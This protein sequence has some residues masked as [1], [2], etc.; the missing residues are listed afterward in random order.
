MSEN[1]KFCGIFMPS[2]KDKILK[3]S[4]CMKSDKMPYIIYAGLESLIKEIGGSANIPEKSSSTKIGQHI[5]CGYSMSTI[6]AF[7]I[8]ENEHNLYRREK[9]MKIFCNSKETCNNIIEFET[10]KISSLTKK[11][12]KLHQDARFCYICGKRFANSQN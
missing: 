5:P 2:K 9:C 4:Q 11:E 8:I 7:D 3:F 12:S 10:K 6:W 1:E